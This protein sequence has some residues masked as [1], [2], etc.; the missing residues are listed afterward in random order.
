MSKTLI[1]GGIM[2]D[3]K[4]SQFTNLRD[5]LA[6]DTKCGCGINCKEG[7]IVLPNFNPSSGDLDNYVAVFVVKRLRAVLRCKMTAMTCTS[8]FLKDFLHFL[9]AFFFI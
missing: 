1:K 6:H 8:Y 9:A 4:G 2:H 5:A 3:G 7:F